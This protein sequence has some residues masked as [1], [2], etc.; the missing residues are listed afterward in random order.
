MPIKDNASF[1]DGEGPAEE[2][3]DWSDNDTDADLLN[4]PNG[5]KHSRTVSMVTWT[6]LTLC[7]NSVF[8]LLVTTV[9]MNVTSQMLLC[10]TG[11][12]VIQFIS[13]HISRPNFYQ[14]LRDMTLWHILVEMLHEN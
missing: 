5:E 6:F 13:S 10:L 2:F 7:K 11:I 1:V 9:L 8:G 4:Q 14:H 12:I 3:S